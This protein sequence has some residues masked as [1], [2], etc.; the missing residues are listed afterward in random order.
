MRQ[1]TGSTKAAAGLHSA[2]NAFQFVLL[3]LAKGMPQ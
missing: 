3:L 1:A 2:Y